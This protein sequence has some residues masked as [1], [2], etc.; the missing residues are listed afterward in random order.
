MPKSMCYSSCFWA[1]KGFEKKNLEKLGMGKSTNLIWPDLNRFKIM[2]L[3]SNR[4]SSLTQ[5][6]WIKHDPICKFDRIWKETNK[7][8]KIKTNKYP[9]QSQ[10][11]TQ[12]HKHHQIHTRITIQPPLSFSYPDSLTL[13]LYNHQPHELHEE[14]LKQADGAAHTHIA[15]WHT[16]NA[17][18]VS[19]S[20]SGS[21]CH[22]LSKNSIW[23]S[24]DHLN[25]T[26]AV[27][28][29]PSVHYQAPHPPSSTPSLQTGKC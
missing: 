6:D 8:Q 27:T 13:I 9:K 19:N 12:S 22:R 25:F 29:L 21:C 10:T 2:G 24:G 23:P 11:H 5:S 28:G 18:K 3:G 16:T 1:K 17:D 7:N 15:K 14:R 26:D 20:T 4:I